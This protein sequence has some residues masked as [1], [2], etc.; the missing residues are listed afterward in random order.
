M[1]LLE[2]TEDNWDSTVAQSAVP[3]LVAFSAPWCPACR[4]L[5]PILEQLA[6]EVGGK[7][8]VGTVDTDDNNRLAHRFSVHSLPT[9]IAFKGGKEVSRTVGVHD[10]DRYRGMLTYLM[11][12][13]T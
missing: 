3:V 9:V 8:K 11:G 13:E 5:H 2:I 4:Q 10:A 6:M 1:A 12:T 7:A